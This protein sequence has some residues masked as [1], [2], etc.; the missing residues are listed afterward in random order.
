MEKALG[1]RRASHSTFNTHREGPPRTEGLVLRRDH[2]GSWLGIYPRALISYVPVRL[3]SQAL[4][5]GQVDPPA[6]IP[7]SSGSCPTG[8]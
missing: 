3:I 1:R 7:S 8:A 6:G 2:A 4:I 5:T